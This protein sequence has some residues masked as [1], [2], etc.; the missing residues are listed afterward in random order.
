MTDEVNKTQRKLTR[1]G[2]KQSLSAVVGDDVEDLDIFG[3]EVI[4]TTGEFRVDRDALVERA[5]NAGIPEWMLPSET[6]PHHAFGRAIDD[7][8]EGREEIEWEGQRVQFN[9]RQNNSRYSYTLDASVY[10][11]A[12]MTADNEGRWV[13]VENDDGDQGL[14]VISYESPDDGEPFVR[15]TD[16]ITEDM[17]LA[18]T[19][20]SEQIGFKDRMKSLFETHKESHIGKDVNNMLYYLTSTWTDSLKLRDACYLVPAN[21]EYRD[22]TGT[23]RPV[24]DL[25]DAFA[26]L[27]D[28]LNEAKR[29]PDNDDVVGPTYA[30]DTEM[31]V[32]EIMDTERQRSMVERKVDERLEGM[33]EDMAESAIDRLQD[34][35]TVAEQVVP[36]VTETL[37]ELQA[38]AG[39]YDGLLDEGS[40]GQMKTEKA[41]KRAV[42]RAL[43]TLD[44]DE[45]EMVETLIDSA[46]DVE[47]AA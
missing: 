45:A 18:P 2:N 34:D 19:W 1:T 22:D 16:H 47:V 14:G 11:S 46:E 25:I 32:V 26:A 43:G 33:A 40:K 44:D 10:F 37:Q 13:S 31:H 39:E 3:Y 28:W 35:D 5:T 23:E 41:V 21:H 29:D 20:Y 9:L 27:Y 36:E 42:R 4:Y 38:I 15:F 7:L 12:E 6:M 17:S 30:Q 24:S 8:L